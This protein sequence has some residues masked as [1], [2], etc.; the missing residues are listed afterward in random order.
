MRVCPAADPADGVFD[1]TVVGPVS[2]RELV[3]TRPRLI[4]GSHVEHRRS[5]CTAP[6]AW[7]WPARS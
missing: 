5:P 6:A 2:R 1:V 3:R 7:S 4:A